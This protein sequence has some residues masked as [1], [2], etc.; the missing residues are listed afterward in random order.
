VVSTGDIFDEL[1]NQVVHE[2]V[3]GRKVDLNNKHKELYQK[4]QQKRL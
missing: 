3:G 1:T 2:Y 4:Y